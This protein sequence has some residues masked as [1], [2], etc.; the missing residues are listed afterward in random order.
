MHCTNK[1]CG[2]HWCWVCRWK[3]GSDTIGIY[4]HL[5]REH[6]GAYDFQQRNNDEEDVEDDNYY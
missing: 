2:T 3:S 1:D 5:V 4:Q 6:G